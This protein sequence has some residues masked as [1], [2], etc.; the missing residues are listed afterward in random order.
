MRPFILTTSSEFLLG[1]GDLIKWFYQLVLGWGGP[2]ILVLA[3]LDSSFLSIPEGNDFLMIILSTEGT[4][5]NM[6]YYAS[7]TTTGSVIGCSFLYIVGTKGGTYVSKRMTGPRIKRIQELYK[8]KGV[9]A[10]IIPSLLPAPTPFK[11]FV[12]SAG[13]F[14][15]PFPKFL[16]AVA[17]GRSLRYFFWGMLA[18]LYGEW[19]KNFFI[20]NIEIVGLVVVVLISLLVLWFLVLKPG[21]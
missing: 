9:W 12:L 2:G 17:L 16:A 13:V 14:G 11:V 19:A 8:K 15:L 7:M 4:W 1:F 6:V 21:S 10:I 3:L 20:G 5:L 18:V